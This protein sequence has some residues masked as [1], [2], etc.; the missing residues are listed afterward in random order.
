MLRAMAVD[1]LRLRETRVAAAE[2]GEARH[3]E[4]ARFV[5]VGQ[6]V[7]LAIVVALRA[8]AA[9]ANR[10]QLALD[11]RPNVQ[12]AGAQRPEQS[13]VA[14]GAASRST[15]SCRHVDRHMPERLRRVDQQQRAALA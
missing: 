12:H 13:L 15:P 8:R 4:I 7:G 6:L 3:V 9:L 10:L 2:P 5:L 14:A 1:R 11:A